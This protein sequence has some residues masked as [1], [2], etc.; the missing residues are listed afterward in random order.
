MNHKDIILANLDEKTIMEKY[1][2]ISIVENKPIYRNITRKDSSGTCTFIRRGSR[3]YLYDHSR[4]TTVGIWDVVQYLH[5]CSFKEALFIIARDFN[6][7]LDD[8]RENYNKIEE[9]KSKRYENID[10]DSTKSIYQYK[11]RKFNAYDKVYWDQ[12][13]ISEE[14]LLK[15]NVHPVEKIE[16]YYDRSMSFKN[17][18]KYNDD[19]ESVCYML[20]VNDKLRFY[21]PNAT[22]KR[23]KWQ[24]NTDSKCTFGLNNVDLTKD[25]IFI[26]SGLKDL[27]CLHELGFTGIAPMSEPTNLSSQVLE[28]LKSSN[29]RI[30][31]LYDTDIAG[32]QFATKYA[33]LNG[34]EAI[35][36][37]KQKGLPLKDVA[38]FVQHFGK[39]KTREIIINMLN[40]T[41]N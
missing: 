25:T 39:E 2:G 11:R 29:K 32:L 12:F 31:Y 22:L 23:D 10:N 41:T 30:V 8:S 9:S 26:A 5:S 40:K 18:Y 17:V 3:F 13:N 19:F 15:F 14:T 16:M 33:L 21:R 38:D 35:W 24:G 27:M 36:L 4:S 34:F 20:I 7:N 1:Y 6:I 37:P 28:M